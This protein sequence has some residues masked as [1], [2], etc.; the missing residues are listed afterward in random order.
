MIFKGS[1]SD[2]MLAYK[3]VLATLLVPTRYGHSFA[4]TNVLKFQ[5]LSLSKKK[6]KKLLEGIKPPIP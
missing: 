2:A 4:Y 1:E 6:K 5:L 3:V